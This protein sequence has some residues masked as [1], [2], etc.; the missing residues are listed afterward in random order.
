MRNELILGPVSKVEEVLGRAVDSIDFLDL[1]F[2]YNFAFY[3]H[4]AD[5]DINGNAPG[6]LSN[7]DL[8]VTYDILPH[9]RTS[10]TVRIGRPVVEVGSDVIFFATF[11]V[12]RDG[13]PTMLAGI[14]QVPGPLV[15]R[16]FMGVEMKDPYLGRINPDI[17]KRWQM[18]GLRIDLRVRMTFPSSHSA[19]PVHMFDFR[20]NSTVATLHPSPP[21]PDELVRSAVSM[22]SSLSASDIFTSPAYSSFTAQDVSTMQSSVHH[23]PTMP[24]SIASALLPLLVA[25]SSSTSNSHVS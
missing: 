13:Q 1:N 8:R 15:V 23:Q 21:H 22:F 7:R 16:K 12:E 17:F 14:I 11:S 4:T 9:A 6:T 19:R 25:M 18:S 5:I 3:A 20:V 10:I 24:P 2:R